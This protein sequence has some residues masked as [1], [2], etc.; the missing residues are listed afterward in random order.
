MNV[1]Q[2]ASWYMVRYAPS[3]ARIM[4][5]LTKKR[6]HEDIQTV[7][8][9]IGYH[10]E[11]MLRMWMETYL[12]QRRG[13][14][15]IRMKLLQKQFPQESIDQI[16]HIYQEQLY[17]WDEYQENIYQYIRDGQKKGKSCRYILQ[18]LLS[19]YPYF[20]DQILYALENFQDSDVLVQ[21]IGLYKNRYNLSCS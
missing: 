10:E 12:Q 3:R 16:L 5:Y 17:S 11:T 19:R 20:H 18:N 9:T 14:H 2:L 6:I 21:V 1:Y 4:S 7:L 15:T 8:E 13:V